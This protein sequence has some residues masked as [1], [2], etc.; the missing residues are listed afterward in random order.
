MGVVLVTQ[1]AMNAYKGDALLATE[2][3]VLTPS[4]SNKTECFTY[5]VSGQTYSDT[6]KKATVSASH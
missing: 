1:H 2:G 3:G 5:K 6:F 4:C